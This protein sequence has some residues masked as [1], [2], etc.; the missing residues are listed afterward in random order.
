MSETDAD[1]TETETAT[2]I[3]TPNVDHSVRVKK[4]QEGDRLELPDGQIL[5]IEEIDRS[6]WRADRFKI[7]EVA[8]AGVWTHRAYDLA[9]AF[10]AGA[11]VRNR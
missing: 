3:K 5:T 1:E 7:A 2:K 8:T 10:A 11:E 9:R 4:L 6:E